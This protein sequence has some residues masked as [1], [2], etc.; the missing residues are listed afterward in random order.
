[1]GFICGADACHTSVHCGPVGFLQLCPAHRSP[2]PLHRI[3]QRP[4]RF[5]LIGSRAEQSLHRVSLVSPSWRLCARSIF[6]RY[7]IVNEADLAEGLAKVAA[8][9]ATAPRE[10]TVVS[11]KRTEND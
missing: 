4:Q 1:M 2:N 7:S 11:L 8:A 10:Q 6:D 5:H 3:G 9:T